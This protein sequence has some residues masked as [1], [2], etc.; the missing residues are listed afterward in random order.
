MLL[1]HSGPVGV[2]PL[3]HLRQ[4]RVQRRRRFLPSLPGI[5]AELTGVA[6][7][8][9]LTP[10]QGRVRSLAGPRGAHESMAAPDRSARGLNSTPPRHSD[11]TRRSPV[12]PGA[13]S[14][15]TLQPPAYLVEGR[16]WVPIWLALIGSRT[17]TRGLS[18]LPDGGLV[19]DHFSTASSPRRGRSSR[20][21]VANDR[22]GGEGETT[23]ASVELLEG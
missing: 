16:P 15:G 9:F 11:G 21:D 20:H 10:Y 8:I 23:R 12:C 1:R 18:S 19:C 13:R 2:P 7:P 14:Q 6:R 17:T 3:C 5:A 4:V 22:S